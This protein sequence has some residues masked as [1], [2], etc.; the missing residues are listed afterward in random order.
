MCRH[1]RILNKVIKCDFL[2]VFSGIKKKGTATECLPILWNA[3]MNDQ[4]K[5]Q[6]NDKS[7]ENHFWNE[8]KEKKKRNKY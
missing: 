2:T 1:T 4:N 3:E 8:N 6:T 5:R 7:D